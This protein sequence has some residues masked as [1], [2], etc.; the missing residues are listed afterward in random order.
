[1]TMPPYN[2]DLIEVVR[3]EHERP[4]I[5]SGLE[6]F[7]VAVVGDAM[8][9]L[10]LCDAAL[11]AS[12]SGARCIGPAFPIWVTEGDNAAIHASLP[13]LR[14]G[15]VVVVNGSGSLNRA[16]I[17][18]RLAM[19]FIE[20]GVAGVVI[21]GCIRDAADIAELRFPVWCRG[22]NPA[23]PF[24][25]GPGKVGVPVAIG[26][27]VVHPGDIVTADDDGV[28]IVP[29]DSLGVITERARDILRMEQESKAEL[30]ETRLKDERKD[31]I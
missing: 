10:G 3:S 9:R 17:G 22:T 23:G 12:W 20:I 18:D 21:D 27:V 11:R 28:A 14:P 19:K 5:P 7:P 25:N 16:L 8:D 6:E 2:T 26:G 13:F 29:T 4:D 31:R 15:D 1:M 30:G 24:K